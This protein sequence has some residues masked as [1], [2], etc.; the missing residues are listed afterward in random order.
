MERHRRAQATC[1]R[2]RLPVLTLAHPPALGRLLSRVEYHAEG[3]LAVL[4]L[5]LTG[6]DGEVP[7]GDEA[8]DVQV[9]DP[10]RSDGST[11]R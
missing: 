9:G 5:A 3:R 4:S 11:K 6:A 8:L 2:R 1:V 10:V 7:D